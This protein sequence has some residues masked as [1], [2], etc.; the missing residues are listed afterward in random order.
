M[1]TTAENP[2]K[3]VYSRLR[4]L[5][6]TKPFVQK[7]ILPDWWDDEAADSPAGFAEALTIIGRHVGIA[8]ERLRDPAFVLEVPTPQHVKFKRSRGAQVEEVSLAQHL[9]VQVLRHAMQATPRGVGSLPATAQE[10]RASVLDR[11]EPWVSLRG[12]LRFL[13]DNGIPVLHVSNF[14]TAAKR[15]D[16]LAARIGERAGIVL[17]V[18]RPQSSWQLFVLAHELGHIC[19]G[20]VQPDGVL[21][22]ASIDQESDD[23][24]EREANAFAIELLTGDPHR[25]WTATGTWPNASQLALSAR[26][27]GERHRID[28]GHIIL[29]YANNKSFYP[30]ALAA[31]KLIEPEPR[32]L[33]EIREAMVNGVDWSRLPEDASDF[34]M[35]MSS[36][37]Q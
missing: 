17:S 27:L 16:G 2:M 35:R 24:E 13:W 6:L 14:P 15:M 22:D 29:S 19:L 30:V 37:E 25:T 8:P 18:K 5:G 23:T 33:G 20:H 4:A 28:P 34:I 10:I 3:S 1:P 7:T 9:S 21:T 31:L 32:G 36:F 26:V 12:L 11:G